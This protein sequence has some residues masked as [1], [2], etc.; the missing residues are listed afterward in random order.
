MSD[1]NK[2]GPTFDPLQ[3]WRGL[4]D[5]GMDAWAKAMARAVNTEEYAKVNGAVLDACLTVSIP[6]R[7]MLEK[8]MGQTL[9]QVNMPTRA[10]FISLAERLTNIEL[11]LDDLDTKLDKLAKLQVR[12]STAKKA[13]RKARR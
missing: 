2:D 3:P 8:A 12:P 4:R 6:F 10:D 5:A 11:C 9:E 1:S 7:N 13:T